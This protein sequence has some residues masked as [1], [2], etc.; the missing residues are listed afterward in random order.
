MEVKQVKKKPASLYAQALITIINNRALYSPE[1]IEQLPESIKTDYL[2]IKNECP[3]PFRTKT[4]KSLVL[5][6]VLPL[7]S[8]KNSK[9]FMT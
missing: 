7:V 3:F 8:S 4:E 5:N 9:K 2:I 6:W 1:K